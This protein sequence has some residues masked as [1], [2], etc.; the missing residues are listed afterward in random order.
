MKINSINQPL[1]AVVLGAS[2]DIGNA[3]CEDWLA[4]EWE[5]WGT[6]RTMSLSTKKLEDQLSGLV[7]CSLDE[8]KSVEKAYEELGRYAKNWDVLVLGPGLQEPIGLFETCNFD[9]WEN[10]IT[11]NF[12]NQLRFLRGILPSRNR[13]KS[14]LG[15]SVI[16]FAGGGVNNA[17]ILYSAYTVAKVAM[18]KMVE[19]LAAEMLDVKFVIIGPGWVKT[20]IHNSVLSAKENAGLSYNRRVNQIL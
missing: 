4:R 20:K 18:V 14:T 9:E 10:S 2:S 6:Y 15:P 12:T 13:Q 7:K 17:P 5:V 3:L 19:L 11:V 16:F 1:K 8:V